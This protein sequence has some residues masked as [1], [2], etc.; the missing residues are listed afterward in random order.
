M[1]GETSLPPAPHPAH[2]GTAAHVRWRVRFGGVDYGPFETDEVAER[3]LSG[4]IPLD[5]RVC[6]EDELRDASDERPATWRALDEVEVFAPTVRARIRHEEDERLGREAEASVERT[7]SQQ[8]RVQWLLGVGLLVSLAALAAAAVWWWVNRPRGARVDLAHAL[9]RELN[10]PPVEPWRPPA[11]PDWVPPALRVASKPSQQGKRVA[12]KSVGRAGPLP[13]RKADGLVVIP[14]RTVALDLDVDG[15]TADAPAA[16][17]ANRAA[18]KVARALG[19]ALRRCLSAEAERNEAVRS[20]TVI[21][22]VYPDGTVGGV[23]LH[24]GGRVTAAFVQCVRSAARTLRV[25]AFE[26]SPR[27]VRIPLRLT[28]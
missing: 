10:L 5:A 27:T 26:G 8:R 20:M 25:P 2:R 28:R 15:P 9:V 11:Q 18:R 3:I 22:T 1:P 6:S 16:Q 17:A 12:K 21:A 13:T 7:R 24:R 14:G 19:T 23:R 4:R